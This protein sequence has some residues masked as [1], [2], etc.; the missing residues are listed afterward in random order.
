MLNS[1]NMQTFSFF[2]LCLAV[3][4][5]EG[6]NVSDVPVLSL[7]KRRLFQ[8]AI[9]F[10]HTGHGSSCIWCHNERNCKV[11]STTFVYVVLITVL[12]T[13]ILIFARNCSIVLAAVKFLI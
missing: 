9:A 6:A 10:P 8:Y 5:R 12:L 2:C 3:K 11:F 13:E 1:R 7:Q 4:A